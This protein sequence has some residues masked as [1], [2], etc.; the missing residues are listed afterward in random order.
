MRIV[1]DP[2]RQINL[3]PLVVYFVLSPK[4]EAEYGQA[5]NRLNKYRG[6]SRGIFR[7]Q[8]IPHVGKYSDGVLSADLQESMKRF[9]MMVRL[10][11]DAAGDFYYALHQVNF[12]QPASLVEASIQQF[13]VDVCEQNLRHLEQR[14]KACSDSAEDLSVRRESMSQMITA[15][16][17]AISLK[18][19]KRGVWAVLTG[20]VGLACVEIF[21][22]KCE[23]GGLLPPHK[24]LDRVTEAG[25][26]E[27]QARLAANILWE[28][29]ESEF[30]LPSKEASDAIATGVADK[31]HSSYIVRE[32]KRR[33][34]PQH[35]PA[36]TAEIKHLVTKVLKSGKEKR[37]WG[38]EFTINGDVIPIHFRSKDSTM[39]YICALLRAKLGER[40]YIHEFYRN[41]RGRKSRYNRAKSRVWLQAV[42]ETVFPSRDRYF[43]EWIENVENHNGHPLNQGKAQA[44]KLIDDTL[45]QSHPDGIYYCI[46][47]TK[48]DELGDTFYEIRISPENIIIPKEWA[49]LVDKFNE[50]MEPKA[51][52]GDHP[53][54]E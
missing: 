49:H 23:L 13:I 53:M 52:D 35:E 32:Q 47:N 14:L 12:N 25:F 50:M 6:F 10:V 31:R 26:T 28:M 38:I 2:G 24:A 18:G 1:K 8:V 16:S 30:N 33:Q 37:A 29:M 40:M 54:K 45:M 3:H 15:F 36:V 9:N 21:Q 7:F 46:L 48:S 17:R 43:D 41:S 5:L 20:E 42:Y 39:I 51:S 19:F 4:L 34:K 11:D 27:E 22:N 44:T